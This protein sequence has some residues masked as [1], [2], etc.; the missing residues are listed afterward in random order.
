V[1]AATPTLSVCIVTF[2]SADTIGECLVSVRAQ[3]GVSVEVIVVD[4]ASRDDSA[5]R[6]E[7]A[8]DVRVI[9][10]P[11]NVFFAPANNQALRASR[12]EFVLVLN[13]DT[14][15]EPDTAARM[16]AALRD[17]S[18]VGA[19]ICTIIGDGPAGQTEVPH[20]WARRTL[21][22]LIGSFQPWLWWRERAEVHAAIESRH[23]GHDVDVVSDAC[24]FARRAAIESIGWYDERYK[25]YFTEDDLCHRLWAAGWRVQ[26]LPVTRV[27][28]HGST[29][30]RKVPRLWLRWLTVQDT[31]AYAR[32]HFAPL[33]F[34][35]LALASVL[36]LA[37]VAVVR[38]AKRIAALA[39]SPSG[40]GSG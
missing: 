39:P 28:H 19:A 22:D 33:A 38:A 24:L 5:A 1:T 8:P 7:A 13:P 25:L 2:N 34:A 27:H 9:R 17:R 21:G 36:D 11:R 20:W 16:V 15:L 26:Y 40:R 35:M 30:T 10:N 23:D 6:A 32:R 29:S 3:R 37:L 14:V 12:G 31:L 18:D 4:N